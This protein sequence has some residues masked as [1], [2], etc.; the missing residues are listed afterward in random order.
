VQRVKKNLERNNA[1]LKGEEPDLSSDEGG[2]RKEIESDSSDSEEERNQ[3]RLL[4]AEEA[5]KRF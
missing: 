1:L 4:E 3:K 2:N 5:R